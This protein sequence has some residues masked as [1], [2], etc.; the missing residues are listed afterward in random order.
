MVMGWIDDWMKN[1]GAYVKM[2]W[3]LTSSKCSICFTSSD[4][5]WSRFWITDTWHK[6]KQHIVSTIQ[7]L[8]QLV[9]KPPI[10]EISSQ[11][12]S[13]R[14]NVDEP[15]ATQ[16]KNICILF[17][18]AVFLHYI[19]MHYSIKYNKCSIWN[20]ILINIHYKYATWRKKNR[21]EHLFAHFSIQTSPSWKMPLDPHRHCYFNLKCASTVKLRSVSW[22]SQG[23]P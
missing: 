19:Y 15:G 21:T 10:I 1:E 6:P 7:M 11:K 4:H 17:F 22:D 5:C 14:A 16:L 20:R 13:S 2:S 8:V 23:P 12:K 18:K 9:R 3:A